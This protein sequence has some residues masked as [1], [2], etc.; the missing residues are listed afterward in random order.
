MRLTWIFL[1]ILFLYPT[2]PISQVLRES[3][4]DHYTTASGLSHNNVTG[5]RQDST[6][7]V[8]ISTSHGLNRYNGTQ[9]VQFHSSN[10]SLSLPSE[11]INGMKWM[12]RNLLGLYCAGVHLLNTK[13][14]KS[15]NIFV[16]YHSHQYQYKFNMV[17]RAAGDEH[18][19]TFVLTRSGFYHFDSLDRLVSRF[20]YYTEADVPIT[21]FFFGRELIELDE[22]RFLVV[23]RNGLNL[24]DKRKKKLEPMTAQNCPVLADYLDYTSKAYFFLQQARGQVHRTEPRKKYDCGNQHR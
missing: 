12:G 2:K 1:S 23:A 10:D 9:F 24:Y 22:H 3:Q 16:P 15:R 6:G 17:E 19:N 21:H 13:T 14:G 4:F 20:D 7:Y 8:W 5:I 18:G 11:D